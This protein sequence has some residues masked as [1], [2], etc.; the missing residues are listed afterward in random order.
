MNPYQHLHRKVTALLRQEA[1]LTED[2]RRAN[3]WQLLVKFCG[4]QVTVGKGDVNTIFY[5]FGAEGKR[6]VDYPDDF[7]GKLKKLADQRACLVKVVRDGK[8]RNLFSMERAL[9]LEPTRG[10]KA[11]AIAFDGT[12]RLVYIAKP[13]LSGHYKWAPAPK[14]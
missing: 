8:S 2:E 5:Q 14:R 12:E 3:Q 1:S 7:L 10:S 4:T 9:A 11:F 6:G 13:H